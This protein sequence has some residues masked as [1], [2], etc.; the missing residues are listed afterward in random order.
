MKSSTLRSL[1]ITWC[2]RVLLLCY[3]IEA[4]AMPCHGAT[5]IDNESLDATSNG[6]TSNPSVSVAQALSHAKVKLSDE[7]KQ[8]H[9]VTLTIEGPQA[10]ELDVD[11]NPFL[12]YAFSVTFTHESGSPV[13]TVPGYFAADG[14][15]GQT[16]AT[17]GNQWRA[18][19]SPDKTGIWNYQIYFHRGKHVA[20]GG[21]GTPIDTLDGIQGSFHVDPSDKAGQDLRAQVAFNTSENTI[22][23]SLDR[24]NIFSRWVP[25]HRKHYWLTPILMEPSPTSQRRGRS[26][27]GHRISKIGVLEIH[28]G[29]LEKVRD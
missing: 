16:S 10:A 15:A 7:T 9:D 27:L 2:F 13:Y 3:F 26:K 19:L 28:N 22:S 17:S 6:V 5:P 11:P 25:I 23:S 18:H 12:D 1:L 24:R 29:K 14:D 20:I 8:W 21:T 4:A